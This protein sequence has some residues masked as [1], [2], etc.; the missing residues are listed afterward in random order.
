MNT[1]R[2]SRQSAATSS[3]SLT[4]AQSSQ[5]R[6]ER[7]LS[8]L[9]PSDFESILSSDKTLQLAGA[10][11]D[12]SLLGDQDG[13][14]GSSDNNTALAASSS[15]PYNPPPSLPPAEMGTENQRPLSPRTIVRDGFTASSPDLSA[16]RRRS[17][18]QAALA[19]A[20]VEG[21]GKGKAIGET[22]R[23]D[24]LARG[25]MEPPP[26]PTKDQHSLPPLTPTRSR[27]QQQH[28]AIFS[29]PSASSSRRPSATP[30]YTK[31]SMPADL[32]PVAH[33]EPSSSSYV[34]VERPSEERPSRGPQYDSVASLGLPDASPKRRKGSLALGA[35][36]APAA[37]GEENRVSPAS[38]FDELSD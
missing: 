18:A 25:E 15:T 4:A 32:T 1:N 21:K 10:G 33:R 27:T 35:G 31:L 5:E 16:A 36:L 14:A 29:T 34:H 12:E 9:S 24:D 38:R 6:S 26:T 30:S 19:F 37:A 23:S 2:W 3:S 7:R 11:R 22:R 13:D 17:E 20:A 8:R 28:P